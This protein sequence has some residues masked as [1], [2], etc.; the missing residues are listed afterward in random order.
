M[1]IFCIT[2]FNKNYRL[3]KK[4][5][6]IPVGLGE[7][8]FSSIIK[9]LLFITNQFNSISNIEIA[10]EKASRVIFALRSYLNTETYIEKKNINLISELNKAIHV[11]DNYILGKIDIKISIDIN[12]TLFC[13]A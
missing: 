8:K 1:K 10:I 6:L 3:F 9:N 11:Y 2:I 12:F 5:N 7:E 13:S 4:I